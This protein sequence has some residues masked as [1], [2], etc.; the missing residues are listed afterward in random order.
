MKK[1]MLIGLVIILAFAMLAGCGTNDPPPPPPPP[2]ADENGEE[3]E[4]LGPPVHMTLGHSFPVHDLLAMS[5]QEFADQV[6]AMSGGNMTIT[7]HPQN[8][9]VTSPDALPAV[10]DGIID[11]AQGALTFHAMSIPSLLGF[12]IQGIY[13]PQYYWETIEIINPILER[14]MNRHNQSVLMHFDTANSI[15]YFTSPLQVTSPADIA[16]LRIRD[17]GVWV[18]RSIAA[19]GGHPMT[20]VPPDVAVAL[21]RGTVDGGFTGWNFVLANRLF[22]SAPYVTFAD[23][24][25]SS[26][27]PLTIN[28]DTY[29]SLTPAQRAIIREAAAIAEQFGRELAESREDMFIQM[30]LDAGGVV[31]RMTE[32]QTQAFVTASMALLDEARETTDDLGNELIDALLSAP[33]R[34]NR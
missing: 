33:S 24:A 14:I 25:K 13:D 22:E 7:I 6:E 3:A 16:G 9:V 27:S 26:F 23:I 2:P 1:F 21:E 4:V 32:E 15:F 29:N 34:F 12:D 19:W 28:L 8:T 11:M 30:V 31:T 5:M 10:Q 18:G 17:H 20:I